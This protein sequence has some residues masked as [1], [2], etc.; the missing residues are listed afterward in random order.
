MIAFSFSTP[1]SPYFLL[2]RVLPSTCHL[3]FSLFPPPPF[4]LPFS[5]REE[6]QTGLSKTLSKLGVTVTNIDPRNNVQDVEP[7]DE[8]II[9]RV[10]DAAGDVSHTPAYDDVM[11]LSLPHCRFTS[12][13]N[14][15]PL[16][17]M[18][19]VLD[20]SSNFLRDIAPLAVCIRLVK[21]D[22]HNNH[23]LEL[24]GPNFWK[25]LRYRK[26]Y[27]TGIFSILRT[28][29]GEPRPCPFEVRRLDRGSRKPGSALSGW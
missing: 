15:L 6:Q 14:V 24:P 23:I 26:R 17:S 10:V 19:R 28:L 7:N 2:F 16:C 1:P 29:T 13:G 5:S 25:R 22:L 9:G 20:L 12:I 3:R 11:L 4:P 8:Q 27:P 21:L 18:L